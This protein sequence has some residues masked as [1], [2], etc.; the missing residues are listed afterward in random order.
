MSLPAEELYRR[1]RKTLEKAGTYLSEDIQDAVEAGTMQAFHNGSALVITQ[2]Q[3]FPRRR[4]LQ[5]VI[6]CGEL[7]SIEALQPEVVKFARDHGCD[8]LLA[9]TSRF[10]W[11]AV[12]PRLGWEKVGSVFR[13]EMRD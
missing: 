7:G 8:F 10:G 3:Q 5:V 12:M 1:Y 9:T 13:L 6:V 4:Y 11:D 2:I